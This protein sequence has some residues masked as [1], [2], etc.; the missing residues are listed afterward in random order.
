MLR[1]KTKLG[2]SDI[3]GVG[4]FADELIPK[5]TVTWQCDPEFDV[6]YDESVLERIPSNSLKQFLDYAYFDHAINKY[7][8]CADDQRFINHSKNPNIKSTPSQDVAT[9]DIH[10]GEELTCDY[11]DY[12]HDW[13]QRRGKK[14]EHFKQ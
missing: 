13:F 4:L 8:L 12:E 7:I 5:G 11:S 1:V 10:P 6:A 3:H 9:K 14:R 2:A